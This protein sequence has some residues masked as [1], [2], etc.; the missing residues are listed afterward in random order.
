MAIIKKSGVGNILS[1]T[2]DGVEYV[3]RYIIN[4]INFDGKITKIGQK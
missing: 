3:L 2:I 1:G 4:I